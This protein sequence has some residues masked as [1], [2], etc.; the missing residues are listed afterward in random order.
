[1]SAEVDDIVEQLEGLL[2]QYQDVENSEL[3]STLKAA[4]EAGW[5]LSI[6]Q[7]DVEGVAYSEDAR[8]ADRQR[9]VRLDDALK[10][11]AK[12]E[13]RM[14][15]NYV[16]TPKTILLNFIYGLKDFIPNAVKVVIDTATT[17]WNNPNAISIITSVARRFWNQAFVA[18]GIAELVQ[19]IVVGVNLRDERVEALRKKALPQRN[20]SRTVKRRMSRA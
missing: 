9:L 4:V 15:A 1:M 14:V 13:E 17:V 3:P 12:L 18:A 16:I 8:K 5:E 20:Q 7:L 2:E 6:G 11:L 10:E 19:T